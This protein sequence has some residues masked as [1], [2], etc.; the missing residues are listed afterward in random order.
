MKQK[1]FDKKLSLNKKTIAHL[2]N[3][4]MKEVYG[5]DRPDTH[6]SCAVPNNPSCLCSA[7]TC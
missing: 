2:D 1:M 3:G 5:G 6:N 7:R 4:E